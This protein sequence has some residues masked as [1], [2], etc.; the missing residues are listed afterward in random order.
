MR[1]RRHQRWRRHRRRRKS[2]AK[3]THT[4]TDRHFISLSKAYAMSGV[5]ISEPHN[6]VPTVGSMLYAKSN[7][8]RSI[9]MVLLAVGQQK[10]DE[11][12]N[13][14]SMR[15][16]VRHRRRRR[17][18]VHYIRFRWRKKETNNNEQSFNNLFRVVRVSLKY[19]FS[20][21]FGTR[22][23]WT[24]WPNEEKY[25]INRTRSQCLPPAHWYN[26]FKASFFTLK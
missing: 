7:I 21:R 5:V 20:N 23:N 12:S 22:K 4:D 1:R 15:A 19:V 9:H 13:A 18:R 3:R 2:E 11:R 6:K 16:N 10:C 24:A 25:G 26:Q 14:K 17:D 8:I